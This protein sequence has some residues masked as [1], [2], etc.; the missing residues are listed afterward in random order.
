MNH[1]SIQKS[2]GAER[3]PVSTAVRKAGR[4]KAWEAKV[5]AAQTRQGCRA[6]GLAFMIVAVLLWVSFD[7]IPLASPKEM[8]RASLEHGTQRETSRSAEPRMDSTADPLAT[9]RG[10]P[11]NAVTQGNPAD[12]NIPGPITSPRKKRPRPASFQRRLVAT[13]LEQ[14]SGSNSD[15]AQ[16]FG[17]TPAKQ[18]YNPAQLAALPFALSKNLVEGNLPAASAA[19]LEKIPSDVRA[20]NNHLVAV[21]GFLLPLR[22]NSGLTSEF[23]LMRNQNMC[24]F[25]TVPKINEWISVR[26]KG[27]GV[28]PVM[29]QPITVLGKLHVGDIRENGFL[30]GIYQLQAESVDI[31]PGS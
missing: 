7:V 24:C 13:N 19:T 14:P 26:L 11:I 2:G 20:L 9:T 21:R 4:R 18:I 23:L 27:E 5:M 15:P 10:E 6:L 25:R 3:K 30:V 16:T 22:T 28:K 12:T 8:V 29:D 17:G 31:S 1:D